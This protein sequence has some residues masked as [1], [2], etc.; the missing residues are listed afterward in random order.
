MLSTQ[1]L[2]TKWEKEKNSYK[3]QEVGSGV[4]KFVK[5]VFKSEDIFNLKEGLISK[6]IE[7]RKNEF[8]EESKAKKSGKE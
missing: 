1:Q 2:R 4:Q 7:K 6:P 5:D 3:K 8:T